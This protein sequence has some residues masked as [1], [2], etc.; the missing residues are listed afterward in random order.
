MDQILDPKDG[1]F[2]PTLGSRSGGGCWQVETSWKNQVYN[3][4]QTPFWANRTFFS[5]KHHGY[6]LARNRSWALNTCFNAK[7][8]P[9]NVIFLTPQ[10]EH[11]PTVRA[12]K[13]GPKSVQKGVQ[14]G[15]FGIWPDLARLGSFL[16]PFL[17][18]KSPWIGIKLA[19]KGGQKGVIFNT[20]GLLGS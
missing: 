16:D 14:K 10:N 17:D 6:F 12:D 9:K 20:F 18:P 7:K 11:F 3:E 5:H 2:R 4:E 8:G 13:T 15:C 19:L 1:W